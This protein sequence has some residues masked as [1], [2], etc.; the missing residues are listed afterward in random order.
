M[1]DLFWIRTD[2]PSVFTN[3]GIKIQYQKQEYTFEVLTEEGMP[4]MEWRSRNTGREFFVRFDPQKLDRA[5]LYTETPMGLRFEAMAYPYLTI[6]RAIQEQQEGE[7]DFIRWNDEAN[8]RERIRRQVEAH[9]LEMEHGVAPEQYGYR[10]PAAKGISEREYEKLADSLVVVP[11]E[12]RVEPISLGE[13]TKAVSNMDY[14]PMA[15]L[16]RL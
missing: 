11:A 14:D 13:Y 15:A 2:R 4:D 6:H 8:K 7:M 9:A 10:T 12:Q 3:G 5:M 16:N 1:V